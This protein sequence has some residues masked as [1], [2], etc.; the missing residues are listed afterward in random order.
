MFTSSPSVT[1]NTAHHVSVTHLVNTAC[2][3]I[4]QV[5]F[6]KLDPS[7]KL[8]LLIPTQINIW[9]EKHDQITDKQ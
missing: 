8:Q 6:G 5:K 4:Q 7:A 1:I 3:E 2:G 9:S